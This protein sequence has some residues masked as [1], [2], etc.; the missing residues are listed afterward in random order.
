[1][2]ARARAKTLGLLVPF[3]RETQCARLVAV[4]TEAELRVRFHAR[5]VNKLTFIQIN[6]IRLATP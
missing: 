4:L 2:R 6:I 1:M 3:Q 5:L